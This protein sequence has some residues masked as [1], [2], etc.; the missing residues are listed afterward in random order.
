MTRIT[1]VALALL[2]AGCGSTGPT[3]NR[4]DLPNGEGDFAYTAYSP[5]GQPIL[6]GTLHLEYA[7]T[8]LASRPPQALG[9]TWSIHWAPGADTTLQVGPQVGTGSLAGV[10]DSTGIHL[11]LSPNLVDDEV[12]L[13][14]LVFG[15]DL[16]GTW[17][18]STIAGPYQHGRFTAVALP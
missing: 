12:G 4:L 7:R 13:A 10:D 9:G 6:R 8:P 3:P 1:R 2:L 15:E 5:A 18:Y 17:T 14:G 11:S 16:S